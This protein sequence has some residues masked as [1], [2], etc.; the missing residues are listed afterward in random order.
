LVEAVA[1]VGEE[2]PTVWRLAAGGFRDTS[3]VAASD[4][5]M[6]LDILS[7]NRAAVLEQL[8]RF[9][10]E[11]SQIRTLLVEND[12]AALRAKLGEAR[13]KRIW[14]QNR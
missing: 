2:D 7:T 14:W 12:E 3:R 6:F 4:T 11:L 8:D 10:A 5:Q 9:A 13:A 1:A